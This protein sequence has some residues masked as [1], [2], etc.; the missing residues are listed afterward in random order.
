MESGQPFRGVVVPANAPGSVVL[1]AGALQK[2]VNA[3]C[4]AE[5][6]I[7]T[8][9][10]EV[11]QGGPL[12]YLGGCVKT[13]EHRAVAKT[14]KPDEFQIFSFSGGLIIAGHDYNGS[15]VY[16]LRNPWNIHEVW[17]QQLKI[18][19][20]GECGTLYGTYYFL[21]KYLGVR[22]YMPGP[23][24]EV[25]PERKNVVI[26]D[27][28]LK[29]APAFSYRYA[30]MCDFATDPDGATWYRQAGFGGLYPVQIIDSF[31]MF[32]KYKETHPEYFAMVDG[33][34]D[35]ST[36]CAV[37]GGGHL[38]LSNPD[39]VKQWAADI[40]V[41]FKT[42]PEVGIFPL[43]P[44]DGLSK[45]CGCPKCQA[46]NMEG[47]PRSGRFS[48]HIWKFVDSVASEVAKTHPDKY[49][50]CLAYDTYA[51]PPE[52]IKRL[53]PNVVVMICKSRGMFAGN[54]FRND[55]RRRVKG[56]Q[57]KTSQKIYFWDYYLYTWLPWRN[58]PVFFPEQIKEDVNYMLSIG[59]PG[60]FIES[61]S[62]F[63][64]DAHKMLYP[65]MQHLN[66]Y[67]TGKLYWEPDLDLQA[68][69]REYYEL[70]YGP[71]AKPMRQF[72]EL[73]ASSFA[74]ACAKASD[75]EEQTEVLPGN[76]FPRPVLD[77][78]AGFLAQAEAAA[79]A[80]S[81]YRKRIQLVASEFNAGRRTLIRQIRKECPQFQV[82][83]VENSDFATVTQCKPQQFVSKTGESV[84]TATWLYAGWDNKNLYLTFIC[85]E[86]E[87]AKLKTVT[88]NRDQERIWND[89]S[90]EIFITPDTGK[91]GKY[92][93]FIV[94]AQ[95]NQWD[96]VHA[97]DARQ[98]DV[99]WNS[100]FTAES[101]VEEKRWIVQVAIPLRDIGVEGFPDGKNLGVNFF[102]NHASGGA[103]E[104]SCWSPVFNGRN[105]TPEY[106]GTLTLGQ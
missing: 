105:L 99:S 52:S 59:S 83:K 96:G 65:A 54:K 57:E 32:L 74:A 18:G 9:G 93:Q 20:F 58:L 50:G 31:Y 64:K 103:G 100:G 47:K 72:W 104:I 94:N 51:E 42:H 55:F 45:I 25:I 70:F 63:N 38:C 40:D 56:W 44:N 6:P 34:R 66:L 37:G 102:R 23:L 26:P 35:F 90:I 16:G 10:K 24:G 67:L 17:N 106:F 73:S 5:L 46:D 88:K 91:G 85:F 75:A 84:P 13:A 2:Y 79:T 48:N 14:L 98:A 27:I 7:I 62:W 36:R 33:Q 21:E 92:F 15:P 22:W 87:I 81:V 86:P 12:I 69:L 101:K 19:A 8:E 89:D 80:D 60:E 95:G 68:V 39:V 28:D 11:L 76:A 82:P 41:Y 78:L 3:V 53:Q 71:S 61:E 1:A 43:V 97:P 77:Q 49:I 30:W 29:R 4:G